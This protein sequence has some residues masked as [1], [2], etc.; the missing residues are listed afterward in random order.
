LNCDICGREITGQAFRV[1]VEGAKMMVCGNCQQLG[2]PYREDPKPPRMI[3]APRMNIQPRPAP[4]R[5]AELPKEMNELEVAEDFPEL[6]RKH[7]MKLKLSQEDLAN[8][9]KERLSVIQK[10]ETGKMAP[11]SRLCRALEHELK[12]KLLIPRKEL[13][14]VP[15]S[16]APTEVTL[17]DIIRVKGKTKLEF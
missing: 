16:A 12:I 2:K 13:T 1:T 14:D 8:R 4:R 9:V 7:R 15:K 5:V 17:G 11:N 3:S 6:V 10:I